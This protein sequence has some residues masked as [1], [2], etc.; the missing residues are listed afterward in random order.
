MGTY[1]ISIQWEFNLSYDQKKPNQNS[2]NLCAYLMGYNV[3]F[4]NPIHINLL[5][6][7]SYEQPYNTGLP[8]EVNT[9]V[10]LIPGCDSL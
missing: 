8:A 10:E 2:I 6:Q 1:G 5:Y 3:N 9:T 4:Q 7:L